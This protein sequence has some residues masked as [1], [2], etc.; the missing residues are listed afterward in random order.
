M[1]G[2]L[3]RRG[4]QMLLVLF[5]SSVAI[6][7]L[8]LAAPGGPF[9][10]LRQFSSA[11]ERVSDEQIKNMEK[12]LGLHLPVQMQYVAWLTG[13]DWMGSI[14]PDWEG[15]RE[16]VL[17][18]DFGKS[19]KTRRQVSD[20]ISERL[21][22]TIKLMGAAS[23]LAILVAVPIG[24]YSAV[25][26]YSKLDYAFTFGTF[27][28]IAIPNFWFGLMMIIVFG[29]MFK[30]WGLPTLPFAGTES[31][32]VRDGTM[33]YALGG[34]PGSITDQFLHLLL[35]M[36]T[37]SLSSMAGW[38]RFVRSSMLEVLKQDYVRTA[39]AKGLSERLVIAKHALR[40]ALIPLVTIITFELPALF[41]GAVLTETVFSWPGMGKMYIDALVGFD[42]PVA[43]GF[44][45]ISAVLVVI[46]TL[47]S[48][49]LYT[50][51]DPRIR[52]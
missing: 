39:R 14:N 11:K 38:G 3:I 32:R 19:F 48:D 21:P 10:G 22:N 13:D 45:V 30:S 25:K 7:S 36:L 41:G 49:V 42:Y 16:G 34:T 51:V 24:V 44:L 23:L 26:Q 37:L 43:Q 33:L 28:G 35:P 52:F 17:R 12:L 50:I 4:L 18:G 8:L 2:Y 6:Y 27:V 31:V 46:A 40:N 47:A 5:L 9:S 20:M 15:T 29:V 1:T